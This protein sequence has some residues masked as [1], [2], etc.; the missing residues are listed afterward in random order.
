MIRF[1]NHKA[2]FLLAL[3]ASAALL[4]GCSV[5][6]S[7]KS[8]DT[9]GDGVFSADEVTAASERLQKLT[10]GEYK[11]SMELVEIVDSSM[12]EEDITQAKEGLAMMS[13]MAPAKCVTGEG[14]DEGIVNLAKEMQSGDCETTRLSSSVSEID[15]E[16]TCTA[17]QGTTT[18]ALTGTAR[19]TSSEM[20]MTMTQ[21]LA[22]GATEQKKAVMRVSMKRT[23]DCPA[24]G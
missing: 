12:S 11:L 3:S 2:A 19:E 24:Q 8:G 14:E 5:A 10:P 20:T 16:M 1:T 13:E 21:P 15:A 4:A 6:D 7:E 22:D 18:V 17:P 9:D 23:G